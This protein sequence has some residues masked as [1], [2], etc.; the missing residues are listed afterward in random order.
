MSKEIIKS[1]GYDQHDMIKDILNLHNNG[2][3]FELDTT[4]S[5]GNFYQKNGKAIIEEPLYK[6][7]MY[8][9]IDGVQKLTF[10]L[11]FCDNS[12]QSIMFDPP[13]VISKGD[14]LNNGNSRSN[15]IS[16]RFSSYESPL[17]LFISYDTNLKEYYRILKNDGIL[18]FKC[19]GTVSSGKNF[20][21]P[22]WVMWR[23]YHIG[24]YPLDRFELIARSRLISGKVKTQ[25]HA[26]KYSSVFW[27]FKK[28]TPRVNYNQFDEI[29]D[30]L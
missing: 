29:I 23:A 22:E 20:F 5:I 10:P 12:I 15:I 19:Q 8:P 4:F 16:K 18:V 7:D 14:S 2:L 27:I 26:R 28:C 6:F 13:F 24:F 25:Q 21:I 9:Q 3:P 1:I 17:D 30:L 11:P